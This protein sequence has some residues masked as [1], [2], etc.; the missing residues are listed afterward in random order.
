MA[1]D[2]EGHFVTPGFIDGH[3][4]MDA[5]VCWDPLGTCSSWHGVTTVVMGNCGFTVAPC[6][7]SEKYLAIRS[8]ERAED[9]SGVAME[10]GIDWRW[11]TF[12]EFL[13]TLESLPKG[14]NYSGYIGHSALRTY[15]MGER[16][17]DGPASEADL[18]A[19][20]R[21]LRNALMAGTNVQYANGKTARASVAGTDIL[22]VTEIR[23]AVRTLKKN[24]ANPFTSGPDGAARR[25]H[26]ICICSPDATY[27]LQSDSLWQDVSK[28]S[29][30]EQIYSGEIGRLFGVVFV[31]ASN[32][33]TLAAAGAS[34]ADLQQTIVFGE[35][36][37]GVVDI[38]GSSAI[39]SIVKPK[40]SAGSADPLDQISTVGAKI[41]AFTVK[42]LN[43]AW[44]VRIEH[45]FTA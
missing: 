11:T 36:A 23:K 5:Q 41:D 28:Y 24:H 33:P 45:G 16:A 22:T 42:I 34:S 7:S 2:A 38:N 6:R 29:N 31:E 32:A 14:I 17:F 4:H 3:T 9:I 25:P 39:H 43:D 10:A 20:E 8:L 1:V 13:D 21:E 35:E 37:Y 40:G 26:F 18:A 27:D 44:I 19:M 12:P 30:A 15:V